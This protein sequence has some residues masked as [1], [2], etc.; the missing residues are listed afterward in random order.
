MRHSVCLLLAAAAALGCRTTPTPRPNG[1]A[2]DTP[3][4]GPSSAGGELAVRAVEAPA[5]P[6]CEA[7]DALTA[8]HL[9]EGV[10]ATPSIA[11]AS[12]GDG[13]LIAFVTAAARGAETRIQLLPLNAQGSPTTEQGTLFSSVTLTDSGAS[14]AFPALAATANGYLLAWRSGPPG[15]HVLSARTI[16]ADGAPSGDTVRFSQGPSCWFGAPALAVIDGHRYIAAAYSTA[17]APMAGTDDGVAWATHI[18]LATEQGTPR[19]FEAPAGAYFD[20]AAPVIVNTPAGVRVYATVA[21]RDHG[22]GDERALVRFGDPDNTNLTMVARDLTS[23]SA[24]SLPDGVLMTWRARMTRRDTAS[25]SVFFPH[26]GEVTAPPITLGT[27]RGAY[28]ARAQLV[29]LGNDLFGAVTVATLSDDAVGSLNVSLVRAHGEY[30]GRAPILTAFSARSSRVAIAPAR[31]G[32]ADPSAWVIID[33]YDSQRAGPELLVTRMRCDP[34]RPAE[35]LDVPPGTFAQDVSAADEAPVTIARLAA[36]RT[37]LTCQTRATGTFTT[38]LSGAEDAL[39]GSTAAVVT[40]PQGAT[41]LAV[42]KTSADAHTRLMAAT[43]DARGTMSPARAIMNDAQELLA[44]EP[45][46]GG[47]LAVATYTFQ[48]HERTDFAWIRGAATAHALLPSGLRDASSAVIVPE[49]S[50]VFMTAEDDAGETV[51]AQIPWTAGRIGAPVTLARL[52]RG[53]AVVDAAREGNATQLLLVRP[54]AMGGGVGQSIA[55][56]TVTA[57]MRPTAAQVAATDVFADPMGHHR[58][59]V[60]WTRTREGLGLVYNERSTLRVEN[61]SN[62][63]VHDP[64]SVLE[65]LPGGGVMHAAAW[66]GGMRWLALSTGV[67]EGDRGDTRAITLAVIDERGALR[68]VSAKVPNDASAIA[69]G[70]VLGVQGNRVVVLHPRT[71]GEGGVTWSWV[72]ATCTLPGGGS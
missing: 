53:D 71:R 57:G 16:G 4:T 26:A 10:P 69:E 30:V 49:A 25:R 44:A 7:T 23:P 2:P 42:A 38:H 35:P 47:V 43:I 40:T 41:L 1:T 13:A 31:P 59:A 58:D 34:Q 64:R 21:R 68:G 60:Q 56:F 48:G 3:S 61:V 72:D 50:A 54:D 28:D 22:L 52:R 19:I 45:I 27:Y 65:T 36:S 29:P 6:S 67:P 62:G 20:G 15:Q 14:P 5:V 39:A 51:L 46:G 9:T 37:E 12:Q 17:R 11:R 70:A 66:S 63:R 24:L 32:A 8:G 33:G 18:V 55:R